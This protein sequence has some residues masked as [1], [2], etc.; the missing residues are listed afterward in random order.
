MAVPTGHAVFGSV[1]E[2]LA[3][4]SLSQLLGA[5]VASVGVTPLESNGFSVNEL[6]WVQ[7][8][9]GWC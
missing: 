9:T 7:A 5:P 6:S 2:M 8:T 1:E 3:P 4:S